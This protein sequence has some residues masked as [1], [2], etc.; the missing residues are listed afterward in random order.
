MLMLLLMMVGVRVV[1]VNPG[2]EV[3]ELEGEWKGRANSWKAISVGFCSA[4]QAWDRR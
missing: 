4:G 1:R 3:V 2:S